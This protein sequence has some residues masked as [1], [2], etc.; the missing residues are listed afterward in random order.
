MTAA[1][2]TSFC[3]NCG[4]EYLKR[5]ALQR[6]CG[7]KCALE[8]SEK[9]RI[10]TEKRAHRKKDRETKERLKTVPDLVKGAGR[11][12]NRYIRA[13][14]TGKSC[15][16]CGDPFAGVRFTDVIEAGHFR[17][18]AAA[19]H[20]RFNLLN[21]WGQCSGCNR[22]GKAQKYHTMESTN[23]AYRRGL[24]DRIGEDRVQALE[25]DNRIAK[26]DKDYLRRLKRIFNRR[27]RYYEKRR[28]AI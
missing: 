12:F 11:A 24:V 2:K 9:K 4:G 20:L 14:D 27:A 15:I 18:V 21:C 23:R 19:G 13:R 16:S 5:Q 26:W 3:R 8:L 7:L 17:T 28:A 10:E 25:N 1:H 22:G 6:V